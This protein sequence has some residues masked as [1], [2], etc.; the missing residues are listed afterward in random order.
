MLSSQMVIDVVV[1]EGPNP[2]S[3]P[4]LR[5]LHVLGLRTGPSLLRGRRG[6]LY[7]YV[8]DKHLL[9]ALGTS[10]LA[11]LSPRKIRAW[12]SNNAKDHPAMA[13]KAY[14]LLSSIMRKVVDGNLS[15]SHRKVEGAGAE[16]AAERPIAS[17]NELELLSRSMPGHLRIV[18]QIATWCQLR[19][20]EIL[21]LR[22]M[23]VDL[24]QGEIRIIQ[25][26]TFGMDGKPIV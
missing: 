21:G 3:R 22:R 25:I 10:T 11:G 16:H 15:I 4:F 23:D 20:G 5:P 18:V 8:L 26:R 14:R 12:H 1:L 24:R 2:R 13:S 6:E 7:R 19:R 17:V 9:S